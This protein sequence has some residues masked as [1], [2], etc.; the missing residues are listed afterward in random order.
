MTQMNTDVKKRNGYAQRL[1]NDSEKKT[2]GRIT[3]NHTKLTKREQKK[4]ESADFC[5]TR[6]NSLNSLSFVP[7][8]FFVVKRFRSRTLQS[9]GVRCPKWVYCSVVRIGRHGS[10]YPLRERVLHRNIPLKDCPEYAGWVS[11]MVLL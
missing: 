4:Q 7:F 5:V 6:N 11:K 8:V 2:M 1:S 9:V 10:E 3:T